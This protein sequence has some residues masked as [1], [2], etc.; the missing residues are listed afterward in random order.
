MTGAGGRRQLLILG[1]GP[2]QVPLIRQALARSLRVITLDYLPD[3]VGH[4]L[5]S[6]S[7]NCSTVDQEGVLRAACDLRVDGILTFASDVATPTLAYVTQRL[8]LPGP[9]PET[10]KAMVIKDCFREHQRRLGLRGCAFVAGDSPALVEVALGDLQWPVVVKPVD[11]SGSRGIRVLDTRAEGPLLKAF[12]H[13]RE[14]S[15]SGRV[16]IE[17]WVA[18][19]DVSGDFFL[20]GGRVVAGMIT[21][22]FTDGTV[23]VGHV[24]P[25]P[26]PSA[27]QKAVRREIERTCASLGYTEGPLD[28]DLRVAGDTTTVIEISP[29]LGGNGIPQLI[30]RCSGTD[31]IDMAISYALGESVAPALAA[32]ARQCASLVFGSPRAGILRSIAAPKALRRAVPEIF[33][34]ILNRTLGQRVTA[35]GCSPD[36]IGCVLFDVP[37]DCSYPEMTAR[38]RAALQ[39]RVE[40]DGDGPA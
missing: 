30:A 27:Q 2:N 15:R 8:G 38:I 7:V 33:D 29:R 14:Q 37:A 1:A 40:A 21:Q 10:V 18:G 13:A 6:A 31:L 3:N 9:S 20:A 32:L 26:L 17:E 24:L 22:K 11:V 36:M 12:E 4:A 34:L 39:I 28:C 19:E 5:A 23:P 16:C 35:F 25:S